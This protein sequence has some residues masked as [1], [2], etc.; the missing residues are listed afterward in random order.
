[1]SEF[2]TDIV[3][4]PSLRLSAEE[5]EMFQDMT[6]ELLAKFH[7]KMQSLLASA[8]LLGN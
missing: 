5:V 4:V 7:G 2:A 8:S 3:G 6:G 1:M